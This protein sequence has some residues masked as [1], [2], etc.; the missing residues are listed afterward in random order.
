MHDL[1]ALID[2]PH[3]AAVGFFHDMDH[4]TEGGIRL[5]G[6]PSRWSRSKPAITRHPPGLGEHTSEVLREI[7]YGAREI[8]RLA[9]GGAVAPA[10][11]AGRKPRP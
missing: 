6:I 1:D 7:G 9:A 8:A 2:D 11:R 3:L 10:R 4:P 5:V